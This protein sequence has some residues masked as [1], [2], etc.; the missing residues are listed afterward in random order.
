MNTIVSLTP[1]ELRI[2]KFIG[3]PRNINNF[4]AHVPERKIVNDDPLTIHIRGFSGELAFGKLF[5]RYPDFT[6]QPRS[7]GHDFILDGHTI[8]VKTIEP[9]KSLLVAAPHETKEPCE[10]YALMIDASPEFTLAGFIHK[11]DLFTQANLRDLGHGPTYAVHQSHLYRFPHWPWS[12]L[13]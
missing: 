5:N 6:T 12:S 10:F 9:P 8:D 2:V 3:S 11:D 13:R 7:G 1:E 4:R